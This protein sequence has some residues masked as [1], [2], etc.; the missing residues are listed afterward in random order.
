MLFIVIPV[1]NRWSFTMD[2]LKSL[3]P[4]SNG[5]FK[6]IVVDH[7]STGCTSDNIASQF[8]D[9]IVLKGD[10]SMWWTAAT[11]LGVRYALNN[12]ASKVLTLNND[13]VAE[14]DFIPE[15]FKA[16]D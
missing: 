1:F 13:T 14:P 7:G 4:Q 11:N 5:L 3:T 16:I 2:C 12:N 6:L 15:I 9:V 8:P 10:K